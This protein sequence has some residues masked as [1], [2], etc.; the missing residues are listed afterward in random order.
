MSETELAGRMQKWLEG[1]YE[2]TFFERENEIIGYALYREDPDALYLRQ[3]FVSTEFRRKGL[4]REAF[5]LLT[6]DWN[7]KKRALRLDVLSNNEQG[8]AFWRAMGFHDYCITM[9]RRL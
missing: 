4:G 7:H 1:E 3:F 6:A 5:R 9:E 8:I 2:A